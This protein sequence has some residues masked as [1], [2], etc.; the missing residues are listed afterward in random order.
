MRSRYYTTCTR[1]EGVVRPGDEFGWENGRGSWHVECPAADRTE[2]AWAAGLFDGEGHAC[3]TG[4][5]SS[6]YRYPQL[7]INQ[8][9]EDGPPEVL[10]R[11]ADLFGGNVVGPY[12]TAGKPAYVWAVSGTV[13]SVAIRAMW[14]HLSR[15]KREQILGVLQQV[16]ESDKMSG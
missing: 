5:K 1:C 10:A 6:K 8:A 9:S 4:G 15:P 14:P 7:R 12:A 16:A 11:M 3:M 2:F 13:A